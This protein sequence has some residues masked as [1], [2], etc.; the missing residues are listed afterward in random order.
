MI[1]SLPRGHWNCGFQITGTCRGTPTITGITIH[2][3]YD[4]CTL[5]NFKVSFSCNLMSATFD[6]PS[7]TPVAD[8]ACLA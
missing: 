8:V 3:R 4:L 5:L 6:A 2:Y 7:R 1:V